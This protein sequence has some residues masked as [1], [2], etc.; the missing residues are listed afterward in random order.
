MKQSKQWFTTKR[1]QVM[2]ATEKE[3]SIIIEMEKDKVN[4]DFVWTGSYDEHKLEIDDSNYGLLIF[5]DKNS[6]NILG[7]SLLYFDYHSLKCELRRLV[8]KEK[9]KGYG[10]EIM[11]GF[12][13]HTF[14]T[15][16]MNRFW[17]DV[18]PDNTVAIKLYESIGLHREGVLRQNYKS[19]RGFL[20]QIIYSMLQNEYEKEYSF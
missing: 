9:G 5:K 19:D 17:L 18:Y 11:K 8:I 14:E 3:I 2:S 13:K 7:F 16:H 10:K 20:D 12:V 15:M 4:R 6:T 1:V